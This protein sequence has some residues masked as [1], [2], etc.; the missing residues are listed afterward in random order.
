MSIKFLCINSFCIL[1]TRDQSDGRTYS[2]LV[3][4]I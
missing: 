1:I 3:A 4:V 2:Q